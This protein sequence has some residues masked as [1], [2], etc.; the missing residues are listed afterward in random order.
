VAIEDVTN[1][2]ADEATAGSAPQWSPTVRT[3]VSRGLLAAL[4]DFG[5]L[6]GSVHKRFASPGMSVGG[7]CYVAYR[8]H[9]GGAS[10]R[11]I[12]NST[13]WRRW[14]LDS[15]HIAD[16]FSQAG[17]AQVLT[18]GSVGSSV[19]IDWHVETLEDAVRAAA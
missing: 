13:V 17:R 2:L 19:R 8:L 7:F 14:L 3:K 5:V 1:W 4:R 9:E 6:Q 12:A 11:A 18:Y 15:E 10:S 16:L